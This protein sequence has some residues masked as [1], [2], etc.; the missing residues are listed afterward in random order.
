MSAL[1]IVSSFWTPHKVSALFTS[2]F[3][4]SGFS[5]MWITSVRPLLPRT[6][7]M[8]R[9]T[10]SFTPCK[11]WK[12]KAGSCEHHV[13]SPIPGRKGRLVL[14][15]SP[16]PA[17]TRGALCG[18]SLWCFLPG[19]PQTC[20]WPRKCSPSAWW[21]RR[22]CGAQTHTHG[23][24]SAGTWAETVH[25]LCCACCTSNLSIRNEN[26]HSQQ[27]A[28]GLVSCWA[29]PCSLFK[30]KR[31]HAWNIQIPGID[32]CV[33]HGSPCSHRGLTGSPDRQVNK[34]ARSMRK[35]APNSRAPV[36]YTCLCIC[37][38]TPMSGLIR[39]VWKRPTRRTRYLSSPSLSKNL[40]D[41]APC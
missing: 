2:C 25:N 11:P 3:S 39:C 35:N 34:G 9:K 36:Q 24:V 10:S 31:C 32:Y 23:S 30:R 7:G 33:A 21:P 38:D 6:A 37:T 27:F 13:R 17:W 16:G 40:F 19:Q 4:S 26:I 29:L 18:G 5:V 14:V 41:S 20:R 1:H 15:A 8:L 22:P 12:A 28:H